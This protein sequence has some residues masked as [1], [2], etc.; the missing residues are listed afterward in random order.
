MLMEGHKKFFSSQNSAGVLQEKGIAVISQTIA[1]N[2][3]QFSN[4]KKQNKT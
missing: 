3:D 1:M 2:G 4:V